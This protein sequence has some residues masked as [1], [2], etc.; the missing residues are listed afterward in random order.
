MQL[1]PDIKV[2]D[3]VEKVLVGKKIMYNA[4]QTSCYEGARKYS[5]SQGNHLTVE[6]TKPGSY[7]NSAQQL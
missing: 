5:V 2:T 7:S 6:T 3:S 1:V 4:E